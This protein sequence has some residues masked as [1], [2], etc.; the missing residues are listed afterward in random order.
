MKKCGTSRYL[1]NIGGFI[2]SAERRANIGC[3]P[4][5]Y[6]P[7]G[8]TFTLNKSSS[9]YYRYPKKPFDVIYLVDAT[10]SMSGSIENVKTY[11]V[12]IASILK[13]QMML[14]DFKFGA[15]FYRDPID[16]Q[17]DKNEYY[18]FTSNTVG[19][20]N[21]VKGIK[22]S[23]GGDAPEDWVGGYNIALNTLKWRNGNRLIIHIADAGA[24]GT[25]YTSGDKYSSEG[26]KLDNYI[27]E[28]SS[29][30]ITIVAFKIGS[31]P[32]KS[33][34]RSKMLYNNMGKNNYK[35]QEFDQNKKDP[36]YFTDLVV[37]SIIKVT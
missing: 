35:I 19:L 9:L 15:V 33:F 25:D 8:V 34:E 17:I 14:Y 5:L 36:G 31:K 10:G 7:D 2:G 32:Q 26:P 13:K 16:S 27:R 23:G 28:C 22:A 1:Q 12:D 24:H 29:R 20:Q 18:P 30:N 37:D 21:W 11:C 3:D 6:R 4:K